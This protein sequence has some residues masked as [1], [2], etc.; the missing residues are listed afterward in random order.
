MLNVAI[1]YLAIRSATCLE[2]HCTTCY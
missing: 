2:Q 1:M